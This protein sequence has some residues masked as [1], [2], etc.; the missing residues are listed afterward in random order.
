MTKSPFHVSRRGVLKG[1]GALGA[2]GLVWP[3][4]A[5]SQDGRVLTV[6][7]YSDLQ[8]LDP[9]FRL[10]APEGD[11]IREIFPSLVTN[12]AGDTGRGSSTPP[13]R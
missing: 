11:I 9:A 10:S 2:A 5:V 13:R 6:R 1:A 4:M 8:V 12:A 3:N 7:S